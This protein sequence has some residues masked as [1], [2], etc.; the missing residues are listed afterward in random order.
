MTKQIVFFTLALVSGVFLF[1]CTNQVGGN[2]VVAQ[3]LE[4]RYLGK[5]TV[6]SVKVYHQ[7]KREMKPG[8]PFRGAEFYIIH[9]NFT[10]KANGFDVPMSL[11]AYASVIE[12][13][14]GEQH[15]FAE[16]KNMDWD[17][18]NPDKFAAAKSEVHRNEIARGL[19]K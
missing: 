11:C 2:A 10:V 14:N 17:C 6:S 9:T 16:G 13:S 1:G 3:M 19:F 5:A 7:E 4:S 8:S 18:K 12:N 15:L